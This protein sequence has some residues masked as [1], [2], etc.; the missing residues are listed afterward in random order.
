MCGAYGGISHACY[1]C[2]IVVELSAVLVPLQAIIQFGFC[3]YQ[4][5]AMAAKSVVVMFLFPTASMLLP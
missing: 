3:Q 2:L 5:P 1:R 4:F